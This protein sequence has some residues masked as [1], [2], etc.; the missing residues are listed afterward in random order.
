MPV[1]CP[2]SGAKPTWRGGFFSE[3]VLAQFA[4]NPVIA[5]EAKQFSLAV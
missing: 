4:P 5:S 2:L 1:I 3:L